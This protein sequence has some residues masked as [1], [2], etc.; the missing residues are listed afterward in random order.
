MTERT[1]LTKEGYVRLQEELEFLRTVR[2]RQVAEHIRTAKEDGDI[3]ENAGYDAAKSEQAFLEGRILTLENMI[4]NAVLIDEDSD[5]DVV[6]L[7]CRVTVAEDRGEP[8]VFQVVG[9]AEAD[10]SQGRISN[11]SPLGQAMLGHRA[12]EV[13]TVKTPIGI[14]RFRILSIG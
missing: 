4:Q 8:E 10:P 14:S 9:S 11:E 13:V 3:M 7:G 5:T 2:R 1:L 12:G 6:T